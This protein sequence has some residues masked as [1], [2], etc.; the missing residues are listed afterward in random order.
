MA[1]LR[2]AD[3]GARGASRDAE[4]GAG[5]YPVSAGVEHTIDAVRRPRG[6]PC[7]DRVILAKGGVEPI[8]AVVGD[9]L[10]HA[11][12]E[13]P[14]GDQAVLHDA[15]RRSALGRAASRAEAEAPAVASQ[16]QYAHERLRSLEG[17]STAPSGRD[18]K[19]V[20]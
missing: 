9:L 13:A 10:P 18:A 2:Y 5:S 4:R 19:T 6:L 15:G 1:D 14:L 16:S 11:V 12:V 3:D 7:L 20:S 8:P 17:L